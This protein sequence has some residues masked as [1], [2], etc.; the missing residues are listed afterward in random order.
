MQAVLRKHGA[1]QATFRKGVIAICLRASAV[2]EPM[3]TCSH[4]VPV[5]K[6]KR[7]QDTIIVRCCSRCKHAYI[8]LAL[9]D[10]PAIYFS[11]DLCFIV[12]FDFKSCLKKYSRSLLQSFIQPGNCLQGIQTLSKQFLLWRLVLATSGGSLTQQLSAAAVG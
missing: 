6:N 11:F 1:L 8:Y 9:C 4:L 10:S 2:L 5:L 7:G 12:C 3:Y